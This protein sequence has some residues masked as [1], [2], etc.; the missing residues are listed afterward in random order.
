VASPGLVLPAAATDDVTAI[1]SEKKLAT[2]LVITVCQFY[3][4]TAVYFLL[5][6]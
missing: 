6:N 2:F 4:V 5:K 1:F 3:N